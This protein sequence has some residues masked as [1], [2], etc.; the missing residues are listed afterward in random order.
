MFFFLWNIYVSW[1]IY[2]YTNTTNFIIFSQLLTC[3]FFTSRN[4]IIKYET[5]TNHN[6]KY[7]FWENVTTLII[8]TIFSQLLRSQFLIDQIKKCLV[9]NI[10][11]LIS[12][13]LKGFFFPLVIDLCFFF[14]F[15]N[16]YVI[17]H[18]YCYT[19]TTNFTIFLQIVKYQFLTSRNKIIK[20]ETVT[21]HN[22]K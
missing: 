3:Q 21:N 8:I 17:W 19:D 2:C 7:M 5:V 6:W 14:F 20:Y 16:I 1:H 10:L 12:T 13:V 22:W 18:I 11:T 4:K 15:L 9:H